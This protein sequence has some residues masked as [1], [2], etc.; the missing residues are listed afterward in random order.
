MTLAGTHLERNITI[1]AAYD[2]KRVQPCVHDNERCSSGDSGGN[3]GI[4]NA[5]L[6]MRL[7]GAEA[8]I[9]LSVST[10]WYLPVTPR[11]RE[12]EVPRGNFVTFHTARPR[13]GGQMRHEPTNGELCENWGACYSDAGFLMA[14]E[15]TKLLVAKGSDAVWEWL[16]D[17]Y[18]EAMMDMAKMASVQ[19]LN[20]PREEGER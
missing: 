2:C 11:I 8:E 13:Y 9:F 3:H 4:H 10:G 6:V 15:P 19:E 18:N 20:T 17:Q 16:E 7:S 1:R 5:V 14:E 12:K